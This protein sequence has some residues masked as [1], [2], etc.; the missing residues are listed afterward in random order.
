MQ[1]YFIIDEFNVYLTY[2]SG[3]M[4]LLAHDTDETNITMFP[5]LLTFDM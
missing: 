5:D 2:H 3:R 4:R 1:I